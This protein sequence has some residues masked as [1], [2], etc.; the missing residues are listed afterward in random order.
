MSMIPSNTYSFDLYIY[1]LLFT[2]KM[3]LPSDIDVELSNNFVV[4]NILSK[5]LDFFKKNIYGINVC[6]VR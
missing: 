5:I 6:V 1:K 2:I 3:R 4:Q